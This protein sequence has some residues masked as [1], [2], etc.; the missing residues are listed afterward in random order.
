[1]ESSTGGAGTFSGQVSPHSK[2]IAAAIPGLL[3]CAA[4]VLPAYE[5][6]R[7]SASLDTL[8]LS[9][10]LGMI[11]RN[12]IG[13]LAMMKPGVRL[14]S[15]IFV[16]AGIILYG[17]RLNFS[18]FA[19]LPTVTL[20][21]VTICVLLF[22][23]TILLAVRRFGIDSRTGL[24]IASGTAI[25]GASAIAVLS[26][27]VG[28]RSRE[29]SMALIVTTTAGLI[30]AFIYP[31]V[32]DTFS[33]SQLSYGIFCGST[34]QQM[35]IVKLAS[36]HLGDATVALAIPVKMVRIAL[37]APITVLLAATSV[38]KTGTGSNSSRS[39]AIYACK[40]CWFLPVFVAVAFIFSFYDPA[41][42]YRHGIEP[43]AMTFMGMAL[44][45]IGLSVDFETIKSGGSK[46]LAVGLLGW[47][48]VA[49]IFL[50]A[51]VPLLTWGGMT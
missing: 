6:S 48:L 3:L 37:L 7:Y 12:V 5:L 9:L 22:Y 32:A 16:P 25:C 26:P 35:G 42:A 18:T 34:L 28:A 41:T 43:V 15:I 23:A 51:L 10:I 39:D 8:A 27:V 19:K 44:A 2:N 13:P 17:T 46:P 49:L 31:L 36:S 30:G 50:V 11:I 45:S 40:R 21:V 20:T 33:M 24:L 4:I 38:L 1:M 47:G 14:V 29:T